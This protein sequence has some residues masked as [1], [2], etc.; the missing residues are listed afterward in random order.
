MT[1]VDAWVNHMTAQ[2][3]ERFAGDAN[4]VATATFFA[5]GSAMVE[6]RSVDDLLFAMDESGVDRAL[7][8]GT[9]LDFG[10]TSTESAQKM[11]AACAE[12]ADRLRAAPVI[13]EMPTSAR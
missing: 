1:I 7:L 8:T 6:D 12:H 3:V 11:L 13:D 5:A 2:F 9:L 10:A 4:W